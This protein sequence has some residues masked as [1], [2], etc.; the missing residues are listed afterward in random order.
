V[1]RIR[2]E[3]AGRGRPERGRA[4]N[5]KTLSASQVSN[6]KSGGNRKTRDIPARESMAPEVSTPK[7]GGRAWVVWETNCQLSNETSSSKKPPRKALRG[8]VSKVKFDEDMS[9]NTLE[10]GSK[11]APM[12]PRPQLSPRR[13]SRGF[14]KFKVSKT[15]LKSS[16]G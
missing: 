9:T 2:H 3:D 4:W 14:P 12:A 11:N 8:R 15:S 6:P 16:F 7:T 1:R 13:A 5:R 10:H